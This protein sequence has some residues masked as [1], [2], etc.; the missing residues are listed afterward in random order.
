[1]FRPTAETMFS[2]LS[3]ADWLSLATVSEREDFYRG[4]L[5]RTGSTWDDIMVGR[6]NGKAQRLREDRDA[7]ETAEQLDWGP[8]RAAS[9]STRISPRVRLSSASNAR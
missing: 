1:M 2:K 7:E 3:K 9:H 8:M 5:T 4:L 6:L